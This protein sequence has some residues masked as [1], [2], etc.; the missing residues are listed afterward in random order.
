MWLKGGQLRLAETLPQKSAWGP[1]RLSRLLAPGGSWWL[2]VAGGAGQAPRAQASGLAGPSGLGGRQ[3][4]DRP[5]SVCSFTAC[6][7]SRGAAPG[8]QVPL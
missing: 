5:G 4:A 3:V 8:P 7:D 1:K 6:E 2:L